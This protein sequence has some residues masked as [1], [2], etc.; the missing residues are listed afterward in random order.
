MKR[1]NKH[2]KECS[3]Y[4]WICAVAQFLLCHT[5]V[6]D[7]GSTVRLTPLSPITKFFW[8]IFCLAGIRLQLLCCLKMHPEAEIF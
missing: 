8:F 6:I 5:T 4:L 1:Y 2:C 7:G 3:L